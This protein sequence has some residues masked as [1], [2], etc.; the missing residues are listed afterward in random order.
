MIDGKELHSALAFYIF[1]IKIVHC[2]RNR[3]YIGDKNV[4][5]TNTSRNLYSQDPVKET[6]GCN[7]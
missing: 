3:E 2:I 1:K 4:F 6:T 7:G 5:H